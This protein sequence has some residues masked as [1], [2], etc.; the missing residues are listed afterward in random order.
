MRVSEII[1]V[2]RVSPASQARLA[3]HGCRASHVRT[4]L[5]S[6]G[7]GYPGHCGPG[8]SANAPEATLTRAV[9]RASVY[10]DALNQD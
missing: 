6:T 3:R 7:A 10:I 8:S 5:S 2:A 9:R 4:R 1:V